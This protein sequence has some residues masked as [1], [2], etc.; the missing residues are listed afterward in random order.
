M[1]IIP[2]MQCTLCEGGNEWLGSLLFTLMKAAIEGLVQE[3]REEGNHTIETSNIHNLSDSMISYYL[4]ISSSSLLFEKNVISEKSNFWSAAEQ[5][6]VKV[7]CPIKPV[8]SLKRKGSMT[9]PLVFAMLVLVPFSS[10]VHYYNQFA[11]ADVNGCCCCHNSCRRDN[12]NSRSTNVVAEATF[13]SVF[14]TAS[15]ATE[16]F[17]GARKN[18][19]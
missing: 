13:V 7:T 14:T 6:V 17:L 12:I 10:V 18:R 5:A 15:V 11:S 2:G 3:A 16:D 1:G 9:F 4:C 19:M 8:C